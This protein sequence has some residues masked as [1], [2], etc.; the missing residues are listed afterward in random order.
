MMV[1][2]DY[3]IMEIKECFIKK[4][5]QQMENRLPFNGFHFPKKMLEEW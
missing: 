4:N 1:K 2:S 5:S 3:L